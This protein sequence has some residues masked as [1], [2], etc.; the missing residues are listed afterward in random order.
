M[1]SDVS[2]VSSVKILSKQKHKTIADK[3]G[4]VKPLD[5]GIKLATV[6]KEFSVGW[7]KIQNI[8]GIEAQVIFLYHDTY[9]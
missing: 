5:K 2:K 9:I 3:N 6:V 8:K 7:A 4:I 1:K